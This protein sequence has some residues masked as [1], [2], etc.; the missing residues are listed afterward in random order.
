ME[1]KGNTNN[2]T[3]KTSLIHS[4][5]PV[6]IWIYAVSI[7]GPGSGGQHTKQ[8]LINTLLRVG[9]DQEGNIQNRTSLIHCYVS[10]KI[11]RATHKTRSH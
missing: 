6:G 4:H 5:G 9:Q 3:H 8:D 7:V 1:L 11:R 10:D 2:K